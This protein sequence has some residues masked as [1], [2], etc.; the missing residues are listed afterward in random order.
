MTQTKSAFS[1]GGG[2]L[3]K[4]I[5]K[6]GAPS[7]IGTVLTVSSSTDM[8]V[9]KIVV[10]VPTPIGVIIEKGI[11]DGG[12][13][14]MQTSGIVDVY[15]VGSATRGNLARGF[16][17]GDAGYVAGQALSEA[18]PVAP[19]GTDKHFYEIGH[20]MESRTGAGLARVCLHFN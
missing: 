5:N 3:V 17:T 9:Q 18:A 14:W 10:D 4:V 7:V 13:V 1:E 2:G 19:F 12:E 20:V 11:P 16:I 15:F 6:T 8:G